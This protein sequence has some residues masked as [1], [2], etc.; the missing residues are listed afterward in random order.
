[1]QA[2]GKQISFTVKITEDIH[3]SFAKL[4]DSY[5]PIHF[6]DEF[7]IKSGMKKSISYGI[8]YIVFAA[9]FEELFPE[10]FMVGYEWNVKFRKPIYVGDELTYTGVLGTM[11][12]SLKTAELI[13]SVINQD[14]ELCSEINVKVKMVK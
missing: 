14:S 6:D 3:N 11:R 13:V 2:E 9:R 1:M 5:S 12:K 8:L 10:C 7:A 4:A